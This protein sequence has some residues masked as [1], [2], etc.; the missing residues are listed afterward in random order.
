VASGRQDE[1]PHC[2]RGCRA[3][4]R[5]LWLDHSH[6][7]RR[8]PATRNRPKTHAPPRPV[9]VLPRWIHA[10]KRILAPPLSTLTYLQVVGQPLPQFSGRSAT[11]C[12]SLVSFCTFRAGARLLIVHLAAP[13]PRARN[14][15]VPHFRVAGRCR[16]N[17]RRAADSA[18]RVDCMPRLST[19]RC[20]SHRSRCNNQ[21]TRGNARRS[22]HR[23][24]RS[25]VARR[26]G[27]GNTARS[28]LIPSGR[29]FRRRR[30][31]PFRLRAGNG[32]PRLMSPC[33]PLL[34]I[35]RQGDLR[36]VFPDSRR[37]RACLERTT[38]QSVRSLARVC[39]RRI[40]RLNRSCRTSSNNR[41]R[42][43]L[44]NRLRRSDDSRRLLDTTVRRCPDRNKHQNSILRVHSCC[45]VR[46]SACT[47]DRSGNDHHCRLRRNIPT[48]SCR[49]RRPC[50]SFLAPPTLRP[51]AD[52]LMSWCCSRFPQLEEY[53]QP[54][55]HLDQL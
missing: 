41:P 24:S 25:E 39:S 19:Y 31:P 15:Q 55:C 18:V 13:T 28:I 12:P 10:Y 7:G 36:P 45:R 2:S 22:R 30:G 17:N 27:E 42:R 37:R 51:F 21:P 26:F 40:R 20:H 54:L 9:P 46:R 47:K 14:T 43:H 3:L 4:R 32:P 11:S 23:S 8:D 1:L 34:G 38:R 33:R 49:G 53:L 52:P 50:R 6:F 48:P 29:D 44:S 5:R 35:R 16:Y